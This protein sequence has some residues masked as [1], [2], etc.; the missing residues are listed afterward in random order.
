MKTRRNKYSRLH[1]YNYDEMSHPRRNVVLAH[2][3][4]DAREFKARVFTPNV[5]VVV[6]GIGASYHFPHHVAQYM[7]SLGIVVRME[8]PTFPDNRSKYCG[9]GFIEYADVATA[10]NVVRQFDGVGLVIAG[11]RLRVDFAEPRVVVGVNQPSLLGIQQLQQSLPMQ[12]QQQQQPQ[13]TRTPY[14]PSH[15]SYESY[16]AFGGSGSS[17]SSS[18]GNSVD[19]RWNA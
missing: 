2:E 7:Q 9:Y 16:N 4:Y 17:S 5:R 12:Q 19:W 1:K 8:F 6:F 13:Q 18:I 10:G 15:P 11:I 3:P 14:S